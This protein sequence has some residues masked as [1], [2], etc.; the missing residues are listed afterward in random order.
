MTGIGAGH[1]KFKTC[2]GCPDRC[3]EPN[4]HTTCRGYL[5]RKAERAKQNKERRK[6]FDYY[7]YRENA[8]QKSGKKIGEK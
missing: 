5:Y 3:A 4:C 2:E 6:N 8:I 7:E 1:N